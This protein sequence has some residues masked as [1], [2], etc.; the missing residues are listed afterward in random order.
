MMRAI[1]RASALV[2]L[3]CGALAACTQSIEIPQP[4]A[5]NRPARIELVCFSGDA[6][7]ALSE[8]ELRS[9]GSFP[10]GVTLLALVPQ[11]TRG[12][13]AAVELSSDPP[14]VID[15]DRRVP[16]F[17]FVEVGEVPTAIAVSRRNPVCTWVANRGS[18]DLSA[19][20]TARFREESL[21]TGMPTD[22][23]ALDT[24]GRTGRPHAMVMHDDGVVRELYVTLPEDGVVARVPV[25]MDESGGCAFGALEI[26]PPLPDVPEAPTGPSDE[27][28][29]L[30]IA[31][32]DPATLA[33]CVASDARQP[34]LALPPTEAVI[35]P[36]PA[37]LPAPA[38][39]EIVVERD[40]AG[41]AVALLIGDS[42]RPV[43]YR[44][45][46]A[47]RAFGA[48]IRTDGPV[49]DLTLTAPV[50][51]V[52]GGP[53]TRRYV[54]AI[55]ARDG[56]VMV[57][58]ESTGQL[59]PVG[60]ALGGR[61]LR[62]PFTA[63]ARAI[64]AIDRRG[65]GGECLEADPPPSAD[66]LRGV[67]VS[68][69]LADGS[70]RFVDVHDEDAVCRAA[71]AAMPACTETFIGAQQYSF[72]RRHRP[73]IANRVIESVSLRE[74]PSVT[75]EGVTTRFAA[76]GQVE[77]EE[78]VPDLVAVD[79]PVEDGLGPVFGTPNPDMPESSFLCAVVDPWAAEP[80]SWSITWQGAI[81][82][83]AS[84]AGGFVELG[85]GRVALDTR[86]AL[87]ERGV[88]GPEGVAGVSPEAPEAGYPGD[89]LAITGALPEAAAAM[90][91]CRALA[92]VQEGDT[93]AGEPLLV[94][95]DEVRVGPTSGAGVAFA[96]RIVVRAD[97]IVQDATR[98]DT[99]FTVADLVRCYEGEL[100]PFDIR[101]RERFAVVGSR[102]GF[103]HRVIA[104]EA[105]GHCV[106]DESQP[107][108]QNARARLG[109]TFSNVALRFQLAYPAGAPARMPELGISFEVGDVPTPLVIDLG[110]ATGRFG[111]VLTLP[112][113]L[114]FSPLT[115][116]LYVLDELRRGLAP[117]EL[118]PLKI[119][120][121][122]E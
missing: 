92:G 87:C 72:I 7:V 32:Q 105:A 74:A 95:I 65:T 28:T 24:E 70:I 78:L 42:A 59:V 103:A 5:F 77:D 89:L 97:A 122:I 76:S 16:G 47:T 120:R 98:G 73:R 121:F 9:D 56:S 66:V 117:T 43:I 118:E 18:S 100:V 37:E 119:E 75:L 19:I 17:T 11:Q 54:Y 90:A 53:A 13:V 6:P 106:V 8:C 69:A 51:D 111:R 102:V 20:E 35:E 71:S 23:L 110:A 31:E 52:A 80:Q 62:L 112:V 109:E 68:V 93:G 48:S 86:L 113:E 40:D 55:D 14:R 63:P 94:A 15:S 85:D 84:I 57:I 1:V 25:T 2:V 49:R 36:L 81:P 61:P 46:L 22:A 82:Q 29:L 88:L 116:T 41:D 12:E 26:L 58:D 45:D 33:I 67:F 44:Y 4:R 30:P 99:G 91:D 114:S 60:P 3:A 34:Q 96:S 104:D 107:V 83:T 39:R 108:A 21:G 64:E 10:A 115:D 50:P 79:C 101:V 27:P 38:P